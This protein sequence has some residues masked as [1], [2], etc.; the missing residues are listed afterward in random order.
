MAHSPAFLGRCD[1]SLRQDSGACLC[2]LRGVKQ[3]TGNQ[4][5]GGHKDVAGTGDEGFLDA[6][7]LG[8]RERG[9]GIP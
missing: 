1:D 8:I 4:Q 5:P 3:G 9:G 7:D 6:L 2:W